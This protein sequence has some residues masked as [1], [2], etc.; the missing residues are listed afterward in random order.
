[1]NGRSDELGRG[2]LPRR[3]SDD[4]LMVPSVPGVHLFPSGGPD[5]ELSWYGKN[6]NQAGFA[7]I[8]DAR[9]HNSRPL[10]RCAHRNT[11]IVPAVRHKL[12]ENGLVRGEAMVRIIRETSVPAEHP[13]HRHRTRRAGHA[14]AVR[15]GR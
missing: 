10:L 13:V 2:K 11:F 3:D 8:T 14:L 12:I 15:K 1:M 9:V 4:V 6:R 5:D 7:P